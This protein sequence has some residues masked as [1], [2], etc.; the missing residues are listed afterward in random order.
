MYLNDDSKNKNKVKVKVRRVLTE[1]GQ[2]TKEKLILAGIDL[3]SQKGYSNLALREVVE[4]AGCHN[5]S[6]VHYHFKD[7]QG[8]LNGILNSIK[9]NWKF[10]IPPFAS[11][12]GVYDIYHELI[13]S[14]RDLKEAKSWDN[15][16]IKFLARLATDDDEKTAKTAVDFLSPALSSLYEAI[17]PHCPSAESPKL[18]MRVSSSFL[19]LLTIL[20]D[21]NRSCKKAVNCNDLIDAEQA[22]VKEA[23]IFASRLT[24][25][26][27]LNK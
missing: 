22:A 14:L 6:A 5:I 26:D 12:A 1:R 18:R 24:M 9:E 3:G 17:A 2:S 19:I 15:N 21:L 23:L 11:K 20:G 10:E 13:L 7:R 4:L 25:M 8:F 27:E 16:V